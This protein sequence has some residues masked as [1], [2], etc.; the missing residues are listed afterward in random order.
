[1]AAASSSVKGP[2]SETWCTR[3]TLSGLL[4]SRQGVR[5]AVHA[6]I[7][8]DLKRVVGVE[9]A[10]DGRSF[11]EEQPRGTRDDWGDGVHELREVGDTHDPTVADEA[12]QV[13]ADGERVGQ[14]VPLPEAAHPILVA[15]GPGPTRSTRRTRCGW[16]G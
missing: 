8:G 7:E 2:R 11:L 12:I 15:P 13:G 5:R 14:V 9:R 6:D 1:M 4:S 16:D 3:P 10:G